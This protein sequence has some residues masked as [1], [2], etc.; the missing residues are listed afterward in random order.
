MASLQ[1]DLADLDNVAKCSDKLK[2]FLGPKK[3]S[4]LMNN[5]GIMALPERQVLVIISLCIVNYYYYTI[6]IVNYYT[7]LR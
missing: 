4:V 6:T 7:I 1:L 3:I 2:S 5:A